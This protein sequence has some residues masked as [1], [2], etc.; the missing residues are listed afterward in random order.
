[1]EV[2]AMANAIDFHVENVKN[3]LEVL[4][5]DHIKVVRSWEKENQKIIVVNPNYA[6]IARIQ[7]SEDVYEI[8]VKPIGV[9]VLQIPNN[10]EIVV[11][12]VVKINS[13]VLIH[14]EVI[15]DFNHPII[16]I[17]KDPI[18]DEVVQVSFSYHVVFAIGEPLQVIILI[19]Q[20]QNLEELFTKK[21]V[22]VIV[23]I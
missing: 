4:Q 9:V 5:D 2:E 16:G 21:R 18:N 11:I 3:I 14:L 6:L 7:V 13:E 20:M 8:D 17:I 23:F 12:G 22:I 1:M 10:I 15:L 19:D